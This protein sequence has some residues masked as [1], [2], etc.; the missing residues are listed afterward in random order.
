MK[1]MQLSLFY[2]GQKISQIAINHAPR[3]SW[4]GVLDWRYPRLS[5]QRIELV[6]GP[7]GSRFGITAGYPGLAEKVFV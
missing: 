5:L 4:G 6:T 7:Y 3:A 2:I 1:N